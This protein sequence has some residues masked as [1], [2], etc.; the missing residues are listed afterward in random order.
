M[1]NTQRIQDQV[2]KILQEILSLDSQFNSDKA[3][4]DTTR[5]ENVTRMGILR[6]RYRSEHS[7]LMSKL[8]ELRKPP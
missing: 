1:E 8:A 3:R 6:T 5:P 2:Q 4:L 7:I